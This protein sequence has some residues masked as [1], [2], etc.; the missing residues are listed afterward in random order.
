[1][2]ASWL[3]QM[4]W[5]VYVLEDPWA[6]VEMGAECR[7]APEPPR[8]DEL[9]PSQLSAKLAENAVHIVHLVPNP[10]FLRGNIPDACFALQ[11]DISHALAALR[12]RLP[13]CPY[14]PPVV[15]ARVVR[16]QRLP[17]TQRKLQIW[18]RGKCLRCGPDVRL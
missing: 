14:E 11:S 6:E 16:L 8:L 18:V 2:T 12:P 1:M 13:P 5:E 10:D 15:F 9:V 3:A 17:P 4:G 7:R